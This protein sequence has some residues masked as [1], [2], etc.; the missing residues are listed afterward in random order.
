MCVCMA[1]CV[2]LLHK[3]SFCVGAWPQA[4]L[5]LI[6][7]RVCMAAGAFVVKK[8]VLFACAHGRR[9]LLFVKKMSV[10]VAAGVFYFCWKN[11]F[12]M[13][14]WP[15]AFFVF[16][17]TFWYVCVSVRG[18]RRLFFLV[19]KLFFL[20]LR[21]AAGVFLK[22]CVFAFEA[23]RWRLFVEKQCFVSLRLAAGV[24]FPDE[25]VFLCVTGLPQAPFFLKFLLYFTLLCVSGLPQAPFFVKTLLY[26]A[27]ILLYFF[28]GVCMCVCV[29]VHGR[30][31]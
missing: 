28:A 12:C 5:N 9:R 23:C 22:Q 31:R 15:Q 17:W 3:C 26:F 4:F 1:A 29:C 27:W 6:L 19:T 2:C 24:F 11:T 21:L 7:W 8:Y 30:G 20:R 25:L 16:R 13:C 18:R 10:R 14:A